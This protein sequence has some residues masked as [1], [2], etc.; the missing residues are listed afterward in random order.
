MLARWRSRTLRALNKNFQHPITGLF[1]GR[2]FRNSRNNV[3]ESARN[4]LRR[5][6]AVQE[7]AETVETEVG[8]G[9]GLRRLDGDCFDERDDLVCRNEVALEK[10][11]AVIG[12]FSQTLQGKE[13][14]LGTVVLR[15]LC[16]TGWTQD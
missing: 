16:F 13:V 2:R 9:V 1:E 14:Q 15:V 10:L 11:A 5:E 3:V 12:G 4:E 8:V 6:E 7:L